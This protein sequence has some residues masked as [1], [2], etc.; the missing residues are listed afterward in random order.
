MH[1]IGIALFSLLSVLIMSSPLPGPDKLQLPSTNITET[2]EAGLL[3]ETH[4]NIRFSAVTSY[5]TSH[6][7][8]NYG[9]CAAGGADPRY[10]ENDPDSWVVSLDANVPNWASYCG[11]KI[12]MT[13]PDGRTAEA[14][15]V[16]K[17]PGCGGQGGAYSLDLF[18]APWYQV[19]GKTAADN[20][21]GASWEIIG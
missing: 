19:G 14:T 18:E 3:G 12:R 15:I 21:I 4:T 8:N 16:D 7:K 5:P 6:I 2:F 20:V 9:A 1:F 10:L 11:K 17:C 13:N